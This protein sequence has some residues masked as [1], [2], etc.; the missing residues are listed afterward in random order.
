MVPCFFRASGP[1]YPPLLSMNRHI[2]RGTEARVVAA[3][4]LFA[5]AVTF[6]AGPAHAQTVNETITVDSANPN[7]TVAHT[8]LVAGGVY[9]FSVSGAFAY[10]VGGQAD[11]ECTTLP[12]A[13]TLPE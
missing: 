2:A 11:A 6:H 12:P 7:P 5:L 3:C 9:T 8:R 1:Q 4:G 10:S 13:S